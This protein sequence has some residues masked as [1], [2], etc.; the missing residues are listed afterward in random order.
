MYLANVYSI[1]ILAKVP[2]FT[3]ALSYEVF[4]AVIFF[5][6]LNLVRKKKNSS[7]SKNLWCLS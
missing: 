3:R 2:S 1:S 6:G 4:S 5:N 7:S